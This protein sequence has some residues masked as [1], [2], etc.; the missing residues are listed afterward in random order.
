MIKQYCLLLC[1]FGM[2]ACSIACEICGGSAVG[3]TYGLL[4]GTSKHFAGIRWHSRAF[5]TTHVP[6][7]EQI[8]SRWVS[9]ER[10]MTT[11]AWGRYALS[12]KFQ[13][14]AVVPFHYFTRMEDGHVQEK[15]GVGD[16]SVNVGYEVVNTYNDTSSTKYNHYLLV[17]AG[18][19]MPTGSFDAG[20]DWEEVNPNF[21]TGSGSWDM[22]ANVNYSVQR[23]KTGIQAD[24]FYRYNTKNSYGYRF[25][26][27][28]GVQSRLFYKYQLNSNAML[29]PQGG[30]RVDV[31][32]PDYNVTHDNSLSGGKMSS[33]Q[34]G[35]DLYYKNLMA[36]YAYQQP[37]EQQW[38]NGLVEMKH[39]HTLNVS[40]L[41]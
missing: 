12:D 25:G 36:G 41:F 32:A 35:A 1:F 8:A 37:L 22:L 23:N 2:A 26:Q 30:V 24:V 6:L 5:H 27:S 10:Y 15:S 39:Y 17:T 40:Y 28:L 18:V 3:Q 13:V 14:Y 38:A 9:R 16:M 29:V 4:P 33:W 19:N 7:N 31:S 34:V 21:Q 20:M 11:E